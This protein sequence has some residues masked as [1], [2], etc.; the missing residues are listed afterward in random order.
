MDIHLN[1]IGRFD[2]PMETSEPTAEE[3]AAAEK[4]QRQR[5]RKRKNY[6]RYVEKRQEIMA[7]EQGELKEEPKQ[8]TKKTRTKTPK[9]NSRTGGDAHAEVEA[10]S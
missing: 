10:V 5:E 9:D 7:G 3:I 4:L 6:K 1:F 2:V 8:K